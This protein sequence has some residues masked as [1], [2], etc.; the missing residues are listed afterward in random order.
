MR[1]LFLS[2]GRS[3]HSFD[4]LVE[5]KRAAE[6]TKYICV[7]VYVYIIYIYTYMYIYTYTCIGICICIYT[8]LG[9]GISSSIDQ[10]VDPK[11]A[12]AGTVLHMRVYI[13]I[14][15]CIH[16]YAHAYICYV[17]I[18]VYVYTPLS[19]WRSFYS[20]DQFVH[21]KGAA[22]GKIYVCI[23][24]TYVFVFVS[25]LHV[26][27]YTCMHIFVLCMYICIYIYSSRLGDHFIH[28]KN[29]SIQKERP[30]VLNIYVYMY[31]YI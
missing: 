19:A 15:I 9:W 20:I 12:A 18:Y 2:A 17:C 7:H 6:G 23:Y 24:N 31:M 30:Q 3:L 29:S 14:F 8:S 28:L 22:A 16:I 4:K 21:S 13:Y 27:I 11:G 25:V 26:Y 10:F 5:P 1:F